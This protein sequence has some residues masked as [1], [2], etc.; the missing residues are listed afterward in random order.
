MNVAELFINGSP[1]YLSRREKLDRC[2]FQ[3]LFHLVTTPGE[4][5]AC[6]LLEKKEKKNQA[7]ASSYLPRF[8]ARS[9]EFHS[10]GGIA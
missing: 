4:R 5:N 8:V 10:P 7:I 2:Y 9:R 1:V 6:D 3:T